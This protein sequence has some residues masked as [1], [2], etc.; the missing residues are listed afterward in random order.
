MSIAATGGFGMDTDERLDLPYVTNAQAKVLCAID[1]LMRL[2]AL[3]RSP[4]NTEVAATTG[5]AMS[6]ISEHVSNLIEAGVLIRPKRRPWHYRL[7]P[8]GEEIVRRM[9]G[10]FRFNGD[11]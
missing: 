5:L 11:R 6:T 8:A 4:T 9:S 3:W 2:D 10:K 7:T 1:Y